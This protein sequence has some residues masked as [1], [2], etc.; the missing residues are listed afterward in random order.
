MNKTALK[1]FAVIAAMVGAVACSESTA[2]TGL[3]A[4]ALSDAPSTEANRFSFFVTS[5]A[6]MH[7]LSGSQAGFG[8]DLR[9]GETGPLAG[10][11]GADKIC[12][13]IAEGSMPGAGSKGWRAFLSA[14]AGEDGEP[15]HAIHRIGSGPWYDRL[16]RL[17]AANVADLLH[18][19]PEGADAIIAHDFPNEHGVPN[20]QPD[21]TQGTVDNHDILTGTNARGEL[22]GATATC[23]DWTSALGDVAS[24]GRPRVGHS[25]DRPFGDNANPGRLTKDGGPSHNIVGEPPEGGMG[26]GPPLGS[27]GGLIIE[28]RE[29]GF[30][31]SEGSGDNW[32]S[33]LDEAGCAPGVNLVQTGPPDLRNPTVGSGGGYGGIYCFALKP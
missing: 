29:G 33:A 7:A 6:A 13:E 23:N 14:T 20:Q 21:P 19:R 10:L 3:D 18:D 4:G 16:G 5:Y 26:G 28:R 8:G 1:K 27:D 30:V 12:T 2:A 11:R 17:L 24:E 9:Y 25:W 15:V 22:Y 31:S 32:M